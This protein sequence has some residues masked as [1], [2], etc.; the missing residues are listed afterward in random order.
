MKGQE[1]L[2][3]MRNNSLANFITFIAALL[4]FLKKKNPKHYKVKGY[5]FVIFILKKKP[6]WEFKFPK[7]AANSILEQ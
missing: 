7:I 1:F 2:I 3:T 5:N 6:I 4:F